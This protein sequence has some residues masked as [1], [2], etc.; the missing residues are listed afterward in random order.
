MN[1]HTTP[2]LCEQAAQDIC[3]RHAGLVFADVQ[4]KETQ[5]DDDVYEIEFAAGGRK[6]EYEVDA[7]TGEIVECEFGNDYYAIPEVCPRHIGRAAAKFIARLRAGVTTLP[8]RDMEVELERE[9]SL[10]VY[11]IE[12]KSGRAEFEIQVHA[13][14]GEIVSFACDD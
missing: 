3:L 11:E 2:T 5:L 1:S 12:F 6:Y 13:I 7:A 10:P 8:V 4:W 14:T 9:N